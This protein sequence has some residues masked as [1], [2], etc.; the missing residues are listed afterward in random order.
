MHG[1]RSLRPWSRICLIACVWRSALL[2]HKRA[3]EG[4]R[5]AG[6]TDGSRRATRPFKRG[7][8]VVSR[9]DQQSATHRPSQRYHLSGQRANPRRA[10]GAS[11]V[12]VCARGSRPRS[13]LG[14]GCTRQT[15]GRQNRVERGF[16]SKSKRAAWRKRRFKPKREHE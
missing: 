14:E 2:A 15:R 1:K 6:H 10:G 12:S 8:H 9:R 5:A 3:A 13:Q 7:N 4:S 11:G 16:Q